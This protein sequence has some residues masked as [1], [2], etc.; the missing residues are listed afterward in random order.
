LSLALEKN[1]WDWAS[2]IAR[3]YGEEFSRVCASLV[4]D[5]IGGK[6][7][8][9]PALSDS[10]RQYL[11]DTDAVGKIRGRRRLWVTEDPQ[12]P[13]YWL[14][15]IIV[16]E[17]QIERWL[18]AH[19]A[20]QKPSEERHGER[21]AAD[22]PGAHPPSLGSGNPPIPNP[23]LV[24]YLKDIKAKDGPIPAADTLFPKVR[25]DFPKYHVTRQDVRTVHKEVWGT[26][27]P[28]PRNKPQQ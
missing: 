3:E 26:L 9:I 1:L 20:A 16:S 22:T 27:P 21:D 2:Q 6:L 8:T 25:A 4:N 13:G 7:D 28:G 12:Y 10:W 18:L 14:T 24:K 5:V 15:R 19:G 11:R 17:A 23:T